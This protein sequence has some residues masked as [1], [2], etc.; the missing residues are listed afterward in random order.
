MAG[1]RLTLAVPLHRPQCRKILA[2]YCIAAGIEQSISP[3]KL[4]HF[5]FIWLVC[6]GGSLAT[7]AMAARVAVTDYRDLWMWA[8]QLRR[9]TNT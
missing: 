2:R 8:D 6:S 9:P 5:L 4:R 1:F 3:H 7:L